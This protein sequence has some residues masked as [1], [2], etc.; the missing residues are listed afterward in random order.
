MHEEVEVRADGKQ[1]HRGR[2]N[3]GHVDVLDA[4]FRLDLRIDPGSSSGGSS[5]GVDLLVGLRR[6]V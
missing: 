5:G 2:A 6:T 4:L 1:T 3:G